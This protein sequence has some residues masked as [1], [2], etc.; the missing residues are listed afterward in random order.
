MPLVTTDKQRNISLL[1]LWLAGLIIF[2]LFLSSYFKE[3]DAVSAIRKKGRITVLTRNAPTTYYEDANGFAGFEYD[4]ATSFA[5]YLN[6]EIEF[7]VFHGIQ[8]ILESIKNG[9]GDI[10]A[11]G[12]TRTEM[13][14]N[15]FLFGPDYYTVQQQVVCRRGNKIP[16][17]PEEL[18][19]YSLRVVNNSSY[20]EQLQEMKDEIPTLEWEVTEE[21]DTEQLLEMVWQRE[22]DCTIADSNIVAINRRYYPELVVAFPISEKQ[23][24]AWPLRNNAVTL[25]EELENWLAELEANGRLTALEE[26]YYGHTEFF[27]YVDIAIF[28]RRIKSRLPY[29]RSLFEKAA[30]KY[31]VPWTLLAATAYQESHWRA[32]SKSPTGVRGIMM[33]TLPT[34]KSLGVKSRLDPA[35]SIMGGARY[36]AR[37]QK[38]LPSSLLPEARLHFLLASYNIGL[39]HIKDARILAKRMGRNPDSWRDVKEILPLLSRKKYYKTLRHGYARGREPVRY[40]ENI[41]NYKNILDRTCQTSL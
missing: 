34:A 7:K 1:I 29:Y 26:Q 39:G 5:E 32:K 3:D 6:V 38:R 18:P 36:L 19:G 25:Q 27:D 21:Q 23:P 16:A 28:H 8:Q 40:V 9:R 41:F 35:Q 20:L 24:L 17:A 15:D 14:K 11:A 30:A 33:L 22:I 10:A 12:L 4:L 2:T 31:K 37:L 13:R